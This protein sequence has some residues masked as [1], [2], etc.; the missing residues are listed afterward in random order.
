MLKT[1]SY[2]SMA[3]VTMVVLGGCVTT[4]TSNECNTAYDDVEFKCSGK[5]ERATKDPMKYRDIFFACTEKYG[6]DK[7][8]NCTGSP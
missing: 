3:V 1:I 5:A 4:P 6:Y 7:K 2:F 8:G